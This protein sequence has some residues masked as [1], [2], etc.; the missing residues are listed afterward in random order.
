MMGSHTAIRIRVECSPY[1][2]DKDS[3]IRLV[4]V[5]EDDT[6]VTELQ[7]TPERARDSAYSMGRLMAH[8]VPRADT[9]RLAQGL[10]TAAIRVWA[11]RN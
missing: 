4:V 3:P 2:A 7:F 5:N 11:T 9:H 10:R 1:A 8:F 6:V